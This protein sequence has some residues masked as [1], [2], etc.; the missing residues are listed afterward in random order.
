MC[1]VVLWPKH[2]FQNGGCRPSWISKIWN[3][4]QVTVIFVGIRFIKIGRLFT[5]IWRYND[6]QNGG[7]P[8]SWIPEICSF[9]H[10]TFIGIERTYHLHWEYTL[11]G[12]I[13]NTK[14]GTLLTPSTP[15]HLVHFS[16][17]IWHL[18]APILLIFLRINWPQCNSVCNFIARQL[19]LI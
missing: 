19:L 7:R 1:D 12:P 10:V 14:W 2:Y 3:V 9:C 16:L 8:P 18:V 11:R 4:G 15:F 17:K 6:F 5:E 13:A